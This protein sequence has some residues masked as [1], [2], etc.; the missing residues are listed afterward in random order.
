MNQK[1]AKLIHRYCNFYGAN[2]P[3]NRRDA[4]RLWNRM[5]SKQRRRERIRM[6]KML[7]DHNKRRVA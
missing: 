1:T 4:K 2:K 7:G 5:N 6:K 3:S